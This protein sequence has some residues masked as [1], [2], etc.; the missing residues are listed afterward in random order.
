MGCTAVIVTQL[1]APLIEWKCLVSLTT[2]LEVDIPVTSLTWAM[3]DYPKQDV[4][5]GFLSRVMFGEQGPWSS[6]I[7]K[8]HRMSLYI[9][10]FCNQL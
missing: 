10:V 5:Q 7:G 1:L 2:D 9:Q 8:S 4:G 3:Y 6:L